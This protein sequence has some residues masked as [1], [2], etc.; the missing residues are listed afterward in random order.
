MVEQADR[1]SPLECCGLLYGRGNSI[2][3]LL[4]CS[5]SE[6][7][8]V[9]FS[10]PVAELFE[11]FRQI[12]LSDRV[13]LGIYHSHPQG[14][15]HPSPRD[16]EEYEYHEAACWIVSLQNRL[17]VVRCFWWTPGGFVEESFT[18][19]GPGFGWPDPKDR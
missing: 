5:N 15:G 1:E 4:P 18:I 9:A 12:R 16:L 13:L 17:P 3:R 10:I 11:G 7:S 6:R 19:E 2:D 8:E 14:P